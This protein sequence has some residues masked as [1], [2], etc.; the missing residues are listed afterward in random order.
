MVII[1][2]VIIALI[3]AAA[4]LYPLIYSKKEKTSLYEGRTKQAEHCGTHQKK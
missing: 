2:S 3:P 4:I 1:L